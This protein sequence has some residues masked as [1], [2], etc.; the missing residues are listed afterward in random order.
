MRFKQLVAVAS[1]V[2]GLAACKDMVAVDNENNPDRTRTLKRPSDVEAVGSSQFQQ[3][4]SATIG[5][6]NR[7]NTGMM[8]ASFENA[9]ALANNGL[10][11]RS[12]LPRTSIGNS[13]GN[14]YASEN[15][16]TFQ[17]LSFAARAESDVLARAKAPGFVLTSTG[18]EQ[19]LK[20]FAHFVH[21]VAIGYLAMTYDSLGV[22][23]PEDVT[24]EVQPLESRTAAATYA[25][26][27]LDSALAYAKKSGTSSLP[28]NWLTGPGGATVSASNFARV[29]RSFKARIRAGVARDPQERAAVNWAEVIADAT[30][31]I[32]SNL[33]VRMNPS[34][35]WNYDW[36]DTGLHFRDA[37]WHQM[38]YYVIGMADTTGAYDTWLSADRD[39]RT[40]FVIHT[41]DLRFPQGNTRADQ[42]TGDVPLGL[43]RYI[44]NRPPGADQAAV[45]W[46]ASF[47]DHYR[48]RAFADTKA[49]GGAD[50]PFFT[51]AENDMLAA[52]GYIRT[53]NIPAAAALIDKTRVPNGLAALTG[54]V[55][56]ATQPVPG[57]AGCVPRVPVSPT[58]TTTACGN[59]FEAMKWEKRM[60]T[61][62]T[63]FGAWYF[64]SRGWGDLPEGTALEWPVP[65]Q[66]LD[67]RVKPIYDLG[68]PS[69][70]QHAGVST[71]GFG[72]VIGGKQL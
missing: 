47:Y 50:L 54:V 9:S 3:V 25:L 53:N 19:R 2:G 70:P 24:T 46:R 38:T 59:I 56:T 68:G 27:E 72:S 44:R 67:A 7:V 58:F 51:V 4:I 6:I 55:T 49:T 16:N 60:E 11:P 37:N 14:A 34:Q 23:R 32:T 41:P 66:E 69:L 5:S 40:P 17:I 63:T 33:V 15:F 45:G 21:G 30:N 42:V 52:E 48:F 13:R 43:P 1:L 36:L 8:T 20:A 39:N 62:Y 61:A 18:D 35:G 31:G 65:Y 29:I 12:A 22:P 10:G 71:Y 28:A 26:S 57:G 64:D